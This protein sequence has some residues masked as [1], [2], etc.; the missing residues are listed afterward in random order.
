MTDGSISISLKLKRSEKQMSDYLL[1]SG[2]SAE[3]VLRGH[4]EIGRVVTAKVE[5][6]INIAKISYDSKR[7]APVSVGFFVLEVKDF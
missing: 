5:L 7:P 1:D 4:D 6:L 3:A 2:S